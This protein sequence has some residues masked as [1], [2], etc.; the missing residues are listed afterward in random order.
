LGQHPGINTNAILTLV[1]Q[2]GKTA[3]QVTLSAKVNNF[4][5]IS[6]YNL[7]LYYDTSG[8][9]LMRAETAHPSRIAQGAGVQPVMLQTISENGGLIL[10]DVFTN[11][12]QDNGTL[13]NLTFQVTNP[14]AI[15][16]IDI[17]NVFIADAK[18]NINAL[19]G[20][21]LT[22]LN[23]VPTAF[24]LG[25]NHP[26]PFN[27]ETHMRYQLPQAG[28]VS[29]TIYNLLGQ[30]VRQLVNEPQVAGTYRV[31]WNGQDALGRVVASGI[32]FYHLKAGTF[33]QT[34]MMIFLK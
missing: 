28:D 24:A 16:G 17:R 14:E 32:Y 22:D 27:P 18:G 10:S 1:P 15:T 25:Q 8:L 9:Q 31:S 11:T 34:K 4:Q 19:Q 5:N 29:F 33:S 6:A 7:A 26:N 23:P 2:A 20:T 21:R 13:L 3:D 30:Q 12:L